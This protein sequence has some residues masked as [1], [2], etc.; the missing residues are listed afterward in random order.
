LSFTGR[1][2]APDDENPFAVPRPV[3]GMLSDPA[4]GL[5]LK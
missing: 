4:P 2:A 5:A 1:V 3:H